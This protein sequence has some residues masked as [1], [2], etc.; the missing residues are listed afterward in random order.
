[1]HESVHPQQV[2]VREQLIVQ[3]LIEEHEP[4]LYLVEPFFG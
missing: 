3:L 1:M 4:V 2:D